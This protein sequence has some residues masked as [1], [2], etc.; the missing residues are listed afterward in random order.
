MCNEAHHATLDRY[1]FEFLVD[2]PLERKKSVN[3]CNFMTV[4]VAGIDGIG[5]RFIDFS[6][7]IYYQNVYSLYV[8]VS[9]A[10]LL[11]QQAS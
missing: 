9:G 6:V 11:D 2:M 1:C 4:I 8:D 10:R 3:A 7:V 5:L